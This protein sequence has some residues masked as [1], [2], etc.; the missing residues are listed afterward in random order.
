V[1]RSL[2]VRWTL[3][4]GTEWN[5]SHLTVGRQ[6]K[7]MPTPSDPHSGGYTDPSRGLKLMHTEVS[8]DPS[9]VSLVGRD[10]SYLN[11]LQTDL[12]LLL[13]GTRRQGVRCRAA[14]ASVT[15]RFHFSVSSSTQFCIGRGLHSE[16]SSINPA[17]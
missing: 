4:T 5:G 12:F 10:Q 8:R 7:T 1:S 6:G 14:S 16:M 13:L 3:A 17:H 15:G 11:L 2:C 9:C